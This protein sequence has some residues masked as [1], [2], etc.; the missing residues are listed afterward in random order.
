MIG[1]KETGGKMENQGIR[2]SGDQSI[3]GSEYQD[4]RRSG[5]QEIRV[6]GYGKPE[7]RIPKI[8]TRNQNPK[9]GTFNFELET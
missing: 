8:V 3:R 2:V 5:D 7:L 4:I 6:S 1:E 9:P